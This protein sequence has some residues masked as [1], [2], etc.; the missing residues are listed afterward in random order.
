MTEYDSLRVKLKELREQIDIQRQKF[1]EARQQKQRAELNL[2]GEAIKL[3]SLESQESALLERIRTSERSKSIRSATSVFDWMEFI[4][5]LDSIRLARVL[6][7]K[8]VAEQAKVPAATLSKL[9][10]GH[11]LGLDG[12]VKLATWAQL[13]LD[14]FIK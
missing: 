6:T 5:E 4:N 10:K 11:R 12:M 8:Q 1:T 2:S 13:R 7:W 3:T 9:P 14:D